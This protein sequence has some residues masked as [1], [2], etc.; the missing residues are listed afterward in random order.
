MTNPKHDALRH[1]TAERLRE[2]SAA[3]AVAL[4]T[5]DD[6]PHVR[7]NLSRNALL[8]LASL[9]EAVATMQENSE[10]GAEILGFRISEWDYGPTCDVSWEGTNGS[11]TT[12]P[13]AL[14][15]MLDAGVA[16]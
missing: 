13:A 1:A 14:A 3:C 11:G 5:R 6:P 9:A 4:A 12:L 7:P 15:A 16:P 10:R 8:G 2:W